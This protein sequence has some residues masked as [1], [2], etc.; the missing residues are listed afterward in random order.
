MDIGS[1]PSWNIEPFR[2]L[3][4]KIPP[5]PNTDNPLRWRLKSPA[6]RLFAKPYVQE[7]IK[8]NIKAPRQLPLWG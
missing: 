2:D 3:M 1:S 8:E 4:N 6:F 5:F 7:K